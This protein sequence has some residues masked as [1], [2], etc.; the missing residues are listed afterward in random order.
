MEHHNCS[1]EVFDSGFHPRAIAI[2]TQIPRAEEKDRQISR[3]IMA[4]VKPELRTTH[5][6]H[7]NTPAK[8]VLV[9]CLVQVVI[10][11]VTEGTGATLVIRR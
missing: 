10:L 7:E 11:V 1:A 5:L 8:M 9:L 3:I 2:W 6:I 4:P